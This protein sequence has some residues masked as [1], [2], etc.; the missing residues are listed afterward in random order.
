M[1]SGFVYFF[2]QGD[3]Y[4]IGQTTNL[5]ECLQ[6]LNPDEVLNVVRC[7]NYL[8]L[9]LELYTAFQKCRIPKTNQFRFD[10]DQIESV[11]LIIRAK[12]QL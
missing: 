1:K 10:L 8:K 6:K 11:H 2:R 5:L 4:E 9:E 3:V 7:A 12:S